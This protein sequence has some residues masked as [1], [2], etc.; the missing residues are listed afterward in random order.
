MSSSRFEYP[1]EYYRQIKDGRD[2]P[3]IPKKADF[4]KACKV[5]VWVGANEFP[6]YGAFTEAASNIRV[7]YDLSSQ[8]PLI[9][10]L[11]GQGDILVELAYDNTL[12]DITSTLEDEDLKA[13]L[14]AS[15]NVRQGETKPLAMV[16]IRPKPDVLK[17][18]VVKGSH[19]YRLTGVHRQLFNDLIRA[20]GVRIFRVRHPGVPELFGFFEGIQNARKKATGR[21]IP[22]SDYWYYTR[23]EGYNPVPGER[24]KALD[25]GPGRDTEPPYWMTTAFDYTSADMRTKIPLEWGKL[26]AKNTFHNMLEYEMIMGV[27]MRHERE[28]VKHTL[29]GLFQ[30]GIPHNARLNKVSESQF[31]TAWFHVEINTEE[32]KQRAIPPSGTRVKVSFW[33]EGVE[34]DPKDDWRGTVVDASTT[35]DFVVIAEAP[36]GTGRYNDGNRR[37]TIRAEIDSTSIN[38][39]IK[40][41]Q[42]AVQFV[43]EP[44]PED[45]KCGSFALQAT[46][47]NHGPFFDRDHCNVVD[48]FNLFASHQRQQAI[49]RCNRVLDIF[50]LDPSQL[51]AFSASTE[52]LVAGISVIQG[53]PGTG[54][55]RV[56]ACI[57]IALGCIGIKVLVTAASN[58]G[59]EALLRYIVAAIEENRDLKEW[60]D[61]VHF[62]TPNSTTDTTM[63]KDTGNAETQR[64]QAL[65]DLRIGLQT[66]A[67]GK[68]GAR[69]AEY[70]MA[71][72]ILRHVETHR[73]SDD[74]CKE[75]WELRNSIA[76]STR[77][78]RGKEYPKFVELNEKLSKIILRRGST[79]IV[80]STLNNLSH[81][82]LRE[83]GYE[84]KLLLVDEAGQSSELD[85]V[86]GMTL[87]SLRAVIFTGD[88]KQLPP[89]VLSSL[90]KRNP[91][92]QQ[93]A[94]SLFARLINRAYPYCMLNINYRMHPTICANPN[95]ESYG[96]K[97]KNAPNTMAIGP[98][99]RTFV[100]FCQSPDMAYGI[101]NQL[102]AQ[103]VRRIFIDVRGQAKRHRGSTSLHN[104]ANINVVRQLV[105]QLLGFRA[106]DP[107]AKPALAASDIGIITPYKEEKREL[108]RELAADSTRQGNPS[109]VADV[110]V[111]TVDGFQGLEAEI[112]I[113]DLTAAN[114]SHPDSIGFVGDPRRL[115]VGLTRAK[116]GLIIIGNM[117]LWWGALEI[118]RQPGRRPEF[119]RFLQDV[120]ANAHQ[121]QWPRNKTDPGLHGRLPENDQRGS[122]PSQTRQSDWGS[123]GIG[124]VAPSAGESP[125]PTGTKRRGDVL[126]RGDEPDNGASRP[127]FSEPPMTPLN[128]MELDQPTPKPSVAATPQPNQQ[129]PVQPVFGPY[130][131]P[132]RRS[133]SS[134]ITFEEFDAE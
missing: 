9:S 31:T 74:D 95:N 7:T 131:P 109:T 25:E 123:F 12:F 93:L 88:Q 127:R 87:P 42:D 46:L 60:L 126:M 120:A 70:S 45:D 129:S 94:T 28:H 18:P 54:K 33:Q 113:F 17:P 98:V 76:G 132:H 20:G 69:L 91:Y 52:R 125:F 50:T 102:G 82:V 73:Q 72:K 134:E 19:P 77:A 133:G 32:D 85:N 3:L 130:I 71:S 80:A 47:L 11:I 49:Q 90:S 84:A 8:M 43:P 21:G 24:L 106:K 108:I 86:I 105:G 100:E 75:W 96:G 15:P 55:T 58:G 111:A 13:I 79:T 121:V 107:L 118:L 37:V 53:P 65:A 39:M 1:P 22:E 119:G 38:R 2:K 63:E 116:K 117:S 99:D 110:R 59:A 36:R 97:L 104:P 62:H 27:G 115:N 56:N 4:S 48:F 51:E 16:Q 35:A 78:A 66:R 68:V 23:E 34:A 61:V 81:K 128:E 92:S 10:L 5:V 57:A 30:P 101:L 89:T 103:D 124:Q 64:L 26:E 44:L 40:R 112:I 41:M 14:Q 83:K 114:P 6:I 122:G 29:L 67:G